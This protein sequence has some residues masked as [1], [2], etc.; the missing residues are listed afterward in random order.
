[1]GKSGLKGLITKREKILQ[2][3][4]RSG[5]VIRGSLVWLKRECGKSNCRCKRDKK[6]VSLY[7]SRSYKGKTQ[8]TYIPREYEEIVTAYVSRYKEFLKGLGNLSNINLSVIKN[9][10]EL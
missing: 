3:M 7:L 4:P 9:K 8:M 6:H 10:G 5:N 1:M 2:Q